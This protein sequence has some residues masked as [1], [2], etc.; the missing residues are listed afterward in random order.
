M[1]PACLC[2]AWVILPKGKN[3]HLAPYLRQE[4][5]RCRRLAGVSGRAVGTRE[6]GHGDDLY[7][8]ESWGSREGRPQGGWRTAGLSQTCRYAL[9]QCS[10]RVKRRHS[11]TKTAEKREND[12]C[13]LFS[14]RSSRW[15]GKP[16]GGR[17]RHLSFRQAGCWWYN[18]VGATSPET[19]KPH[20]RGGGDAWDSLRAFFTMTYDQAQPWQ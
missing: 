15:Q 8:A 9:P 6:P 11:L 2:A 13:S 10:V 19:F 14:L 16:V 4:L 3:P 7:Q 12:T 18:E 20:G 1:L 5:G 17:W